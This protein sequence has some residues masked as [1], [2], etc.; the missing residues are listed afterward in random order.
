MTKPVD[1]FTTDFRA[2]EILVS[3]YRNNSFTRAAEDLDINQ[4][5]VSYTIEKLRQ[6]F[7]DPLFAREARSLIATPR[8]EEAVTEAIDLL[9]RFTELTAEQDFDPKLSAGSITIACNYY[10]RVLIIPHVVHALREQAPNLKVEIVDSSYLGHDR[11]LRMEADLLIGPFQKL[12]AAFYGRKLYDDQYVCMMDPAHPMAHKSLTLWEY[13][14]LD[15]IYITYGGKWKSR[16]MQVLEDEG[17]R[18][19]I[20]IKV[21][22][23]AGIQSLIAGT[24]LVA[25]VPERLSREIGNRLHVTPCPVGSPIDIQLVWTKRTRNSPMHKWVRDLIAQQ[26]KML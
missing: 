10:E 12:G 6:V 23:P 1:P 2:L 16:Y 17:H 4:S 18:L 5:V 22:S 7:N 13:L 8:C 14:P 11:L 15:H 24:N 20:A 9:Q 19:S 21:P 3:V 25:T 26:C